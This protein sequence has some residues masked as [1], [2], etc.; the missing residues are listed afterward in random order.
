MVSDAV[1]NRRIKLQQ[2]LAQ[3]TMPPIMAPL[4]KMVKVVTKEED[5]PDE[6]DGMTPELTEEMFELMSEEHLIAD[7]AFVEPASQTNWLW[8][9]ARSS[10]KQVCNANVVV[11][12]ITGRSSPVGCLKTIAFCKAT[13]C[14]IYASQPCGIIQHAVS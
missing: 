13:R 4:N 10:K 3:V 11:C 7:V 1:M 8:A 6:S 14:Y 5:S 12:D 2:V 9:F